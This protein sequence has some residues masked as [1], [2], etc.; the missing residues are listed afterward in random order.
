[1]PRLRFTKKQRLIQAYEA[2]FFAALGVFKNDLETFGQASYHVIEAYYHVLQYLHQTRYLKERVRKP[3]STDLRDR[4]LDSYPTEDF[5]H[6]L[7]LTREH[8]N[9]LLGMVY[10]SDHFRPKD[11]DSPQ[12]PVAT[13]MKVA[14]FRLGTKGI[15]IEKVSWIFGISAGSVHDYTWRCV[16]AIADLEERFI[17]WPDFA[18]K[19]EIK[20]WFKTEKGFPNVVGAVDG[21]P[22]PF[23]MVPTHDSPSWVTRKCDNAMGATGVADHTGRIIYLSTGYVGS[24]HDS[25]AYKETNLYKRPGDFFQ[26]KEY[27]LADAAYSLTETVIPRYKNASGDELRFNQI[28]GSARVKVEHSFGMLKLKFQSLKSLPIR[29]DKRSDIQ[30]AS[31]WIVACVVLHNYLR[32]N[33]QGDPVVED[34]VREEAQ[35]ER[36]I[37]DVQEDAGLPGDDVNGYDR[38]EA[39]RRRNKL[40]DWVLRNQNK[41][42]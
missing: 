26:W 36:A 7:R 1:M 16:N 41:V 6:I 24:M 4:V 14:L 25:H 9:L 40:K 27:L 33:A 12:A 2:E 21:V 22:F 23:D 28:H 30:K 8:L 42:R 5:K 38:P 37:D 3:F 10:D 15:S 39:V 20:H 35:R 29:I 18:R 19:Q 17:V 32:E 13:Q 11:D 31:Q 34:R